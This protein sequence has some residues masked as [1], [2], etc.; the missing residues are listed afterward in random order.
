MSAFESEEVEIGQENKK[1]VTLDELLA[2]I[3]QEK[4]AVKKRIP[5][6]YTVWTPLF[7]NLKTREGMYWIIFFVFSFTTAG[8]LLGSITSFM[9][10]AESPSSVFN[11]IKNVAVNEGLLSTTTEKISKI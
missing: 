6:E 4:A 9:A 1:E 10:E 8:V 3:E 5:K 7:V 11:A 2:Q